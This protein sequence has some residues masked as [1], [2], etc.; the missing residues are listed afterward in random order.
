MMKYIKFLGVFLLLSCNYVL[1][2]KDTLDSAVQSLILEKIG[3]DS[4]E[5]DVQY[6]SEYRERY[7]KE[8][9]DQIA[10][11]ALEKHN[12]KN[13]S[14]RVRILLR[15]KDL[16]EEVHNIS[17]R[18]VTYI[19]VPVTNRMIA[20]GDLIKESDVS[21][22]K[23]KTSNLK[24]QVYLSKEKLIGMQANNIIQH[25]KAL[26]LS[27]LRRPPVINSDD[28]VNIIFETNNIRLKTIAIALEGGAVGDNIKV[29]NEKS[30]NIVYGRIIDKKTVRVDY[31]Q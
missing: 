31:A 10:D 5:I 25:G 1:A 16:L 18:Y 26:K 30:G 2:N 28:M 23:T 21:Y 22:I 19:Q 12:P 8:R 17:G 27:D 24:G 4:S 29:K 13:R 6:E 15:D 14:F 11:V 3:G 9:S 20:N 7:L